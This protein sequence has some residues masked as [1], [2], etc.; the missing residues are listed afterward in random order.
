MI[1]RGGT[2]SKDSHKVMPVKKNNP[3]SSSAPK[4]IISGRYTTIGKIAKTEALFLFLSYDIRYHKIRLIVNDI[5]FS[6]KRNRK[7]N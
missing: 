1:L 5:L 2:N 7:A 6:Y 3:N 4:Y